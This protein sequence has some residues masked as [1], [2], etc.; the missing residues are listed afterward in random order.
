MHVKKAFNR[1]NYLAAITLVTFITYLI[2]VSKF[3][4]N[5]VQGDRGKKNHVGLEE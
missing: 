2:C 4:K 5:I 1:V 3:D